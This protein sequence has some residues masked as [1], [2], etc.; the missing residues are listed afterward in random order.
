MNKKGFLFGIYNRLAI[1]ALAGILLLL[2]CAQKNNLHPTTDDGSWFF[3]NEKQANMGTYHTEH[4]RVFG[5]AIDGYN[6]FVLKGIDR[7][8]SHAPDGGGYFIGL[9]AD[10]PESPIGYEL[11]LFGKS[12][13]NPPRPTSYCSG[14]TY[15]AFIEAMNLIFPNGAQR[16]DSLHYEALRMQEPDGGR[17]ED[18][19]KFWGYWNADGYGNHYALVQYAKMGRRIH[20]NNARPGDFMNISWKKG[21]GHSVIFLG[22]YKDADGTAKVRYWSSQKRTNGMGD[23]MVPI[24][25]IAEVCIVRLVHPENIFTFDVN[26][27]VNIHVPGDSIVFPTTR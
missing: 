16:L 21:G 6:L 25:R 18:L 12:L 22:W 27:P 17:R 7:A 24:D 3:L 10:P 8:Q 4:A 2:G 11:K 1:F 14:S 26:A 9:K 20:P 15:T 5:Q 23:D 19:V 13:L